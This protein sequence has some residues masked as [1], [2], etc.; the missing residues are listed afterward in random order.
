M[1]EDKSS[2]LPM[3]LDNVSGQAEYSLMLFA[4][5]ADHIETRAKPGWC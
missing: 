4:E 2:N 5:D 1:N 3:L